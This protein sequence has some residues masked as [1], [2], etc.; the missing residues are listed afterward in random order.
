MYS[1][2][3]L[4]PNQSSYQRYKAQVALMQNCVTGE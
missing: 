1:K 2:G 4:T 3:K